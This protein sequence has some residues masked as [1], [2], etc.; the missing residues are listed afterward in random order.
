MGD[1]LDGEVLSSWNLYFYC[2]FY[3]VLSSVFTVSGATLWD[4]QHDSFQ[5]YFFVINWLNWNIFKAY[6]PLCNCASLCSICE[7]DKFSSRGRFCSSQEGD[8]QNVGARNVPIKK[9]KIPFVLFYY[10]IKYF[11]TTTTTSFFF[12]FFYNEVEIL[13]FL[14]CNPHASS[15]DTNLSLSLSNQ[16]LL[17]HFSFH[18]LNWFQWCLDQRAFLWTACTANES[19]SFVHKPKDDI[20]LYIY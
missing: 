6:F 12:F 20:F 2:I 17:N 4:V 14:D 8:E 16:N 18:L 3:Q 11:T 10:C 7:L 5:G 19:A 9:K 1:L 15:M 13:L